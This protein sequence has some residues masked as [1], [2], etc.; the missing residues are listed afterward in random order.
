[1]PVFVKGRGCLISGIAQWLGAC[2][3]DDVCV[4]V[5][6]HW[7]FSAHRQTGHSGVGAFATWVACFGVILRMVAYKIEWERQK[8]NNF[9]RFATA[10][11]SSQSTP[12]IVL[13]LLIVSQVVG[14]I[15]CNQ[16]WLTNASHF[17][18]KLNL[19]VLREWLKTAIIREQLRRANLRW[20]AY[21][22]WSQCYYQWG[23]THSMCNRCLFCFASICDLQNFS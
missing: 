17:S 1:M 9:V 22:S 10:I 23:C 13:E 16:A 3:I 15:Y 5:L 8:R 11:L 6:L 19:T 4:Y 18:K 21:K 7:V 2:K 14:H 12:V 20:W